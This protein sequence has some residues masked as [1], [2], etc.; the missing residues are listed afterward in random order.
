M[1]DRPLRTLARQYA[2][3][4]L[5]F[6]SY[7]ALR[8]RWLDALSGSPTPPQRLP[9]YGSHI[10]IALG[11]LVVAVVGSLAVTCLFS[12]AGARK[13]LCPIAI[14]DT[15]THGTAKASPPTTPR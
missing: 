12:D 10:V 9:W 11:M 8:G 13:S 3:G 2:E 15:H 4:T 6:A 14:E 1:V 7:R 5:D